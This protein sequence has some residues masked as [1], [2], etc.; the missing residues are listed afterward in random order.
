[1]KKYLFSTKKETTLRV[2]KN[3]LEFLRT[4]K[5]HLKT[6]QISAALVLIKELIKFYWQL[7][8]SFNSKTKSV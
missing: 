5:D 3:Y 4:V 7:G 6:A 1:M 2:D 8:S